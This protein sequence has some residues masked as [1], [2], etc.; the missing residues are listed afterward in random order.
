MTSRGWEIPAEFESGAAGTTAWWQGSGRCATW[1]TA[2]GPGLVH[3][4]VVE[5]MLPEHPELG[6]RKTARSGA[7]PGGCGPQGGGLVF[8]FFVEVEFMPQES[9]HSQVDGSVAFSTCAVLCSFH[10]DGL[11]HFSQNKRRS[12]APSDLH[13]VCGSACVEPRTVRHPPPSLSLSAASSR[14]IGVAAGVGASFLPKTDP[15]SLRPPHPP[16][17]DAT[18][19]CCHFSVHRRFCFLKIYVFI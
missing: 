16:P 4:F 13:P 5:H 10:L 17:A 14:S 6:L 19:G 11:K 15:P 18:L 7:S 9:T 3:V 1:E 12:P 2:T 8:C